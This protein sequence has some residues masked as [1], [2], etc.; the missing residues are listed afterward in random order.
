ML[1]YPNIGK[2][3]KR[4]QSVQSVPFPKN[5]KHSIP[6]T[7]RSVPETFRFVPKAFRSVIEVFRFVLTVQRSRGVAGVRTLLAWRFKSWPTGYN[8]QKM[9]PDLRTFHGR[10]VSK[11][12]KR[13]KIGYVVFEI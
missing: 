8:S 13:Y 3:F 12:F 6:E 10:W 7:F 11:F 5:V 1:G 2:K 9:S 4:G